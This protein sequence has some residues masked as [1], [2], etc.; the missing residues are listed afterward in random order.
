M[1]N[2]LI[3]AISIL[4]QTLRSVGFG[5]TFNGFSF[6]FAVGLSVSLVVSGWGTFNPLQPNTNNGLA[7]ATPAKEFVLRIGHQKFDPLTLVKAKSDLA[8]RL[9][10]FGVASI[11]WIEFP[12]GPPMLEALNAG[13]ID[14]ARTGDTPPVV[15][16]A[17]GVPL[18]YVGSSA[19][20][21][22]SSAVL[23]KRSS[24]IKTIADLKGKKVAFAKGSS[25]NYL[26]VKVLESAKLSFSDI[27][28]VY[29]APADARAAFEQ[30]SIDAWVIWDP[31]YAAV[32][33]QSDARVVRNSSGLVNNRDF[34]LA[35]KGFADQHAEVIKQ[36]RAETQTVASW[37]SK[38]PTQVAALLSPILKLDQG[39]LE[40][41]TK[42]RNY[43]FE[44]VTPAIVAEQQ[45]IADTFFNLKLIPKAIKVADAVHPSAIAINAR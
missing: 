32:Q 6:L 2:A 13:S 12:S 34:Y 24:S 40:I 41:V 35:S 45:A 1:L 31:F 8:T 22:Q 20:K 14:F 38:N 42:R 27:Q 23:V 26:I 18:V 11:Q 21:D 16:Q 33:V 43:G 10:P 30:G 36:I 5:R 44:P 9:K 29:L 28:P 39:I 19:P 17:V 4:Q 7:V 37:A 15:A 3:K 25:A